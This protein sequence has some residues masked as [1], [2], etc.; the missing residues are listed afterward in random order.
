M[1]QNGWI[2]M[3]GALR[4]AA[5]AMIPVSTHALHYGSSVFEGLRAY[6][7]PRGPAVLGL[8]E[9]L[10]RFLRSARTLR[11]D[12][13]YCEDELA[14]AVFETLA[15]NELEAAYVRP[16]AFRGAGGFH[17]DGRAYPVQ[18]II[19][20]FPW[21]TYLGDDALE[22]GVDVVV[23]SWRRPAPGS[24]PLL[25]KV[26]GNYV[27]S[28]LIAMEAHDRGAHEGIALDAQGMVSEGSGEN[29]F[30][31][32]DGVVRTPP[33]ACSILAGV[34]RGLVLRLLAEQGLPVC[35]EAMPREMLETAD[36]ILLTGTAV[37]IV[38]VRS[39]DGRPVG[40]GRRGPVTESLQ[41]AFFDIVQGR[42][43]DR[44]GWLTP[45]PAPR[46]AEA[47]P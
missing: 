35:E 12:V 20:A 25:A 2:W 37:E 31:V 18:V 33:L 28:Q 3:D 29:V 44:F 36:E 1:I 4:P 30:V 8:D 14:A 9:H 43:A 24:F 13:P 7:T 17:V 39:V 45:V 42:V 34:T 6:A 26:G 11:L 15:A 10:R 27:A 16:L 22:R 19:L 40:S 38:P 41:R 21:G 46:S 23:T 5:Q 32:H 47:V